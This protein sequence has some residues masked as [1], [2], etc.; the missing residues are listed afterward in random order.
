VAKFAYSAIRDDGERLTGTIEGADR[1]TV[2]GRLNA[3]G[4]HPIDVSESGQT[5]TTGRVLSFGGG[6]A[7]HREIS[8]FTRELA[9]LLR[10][11]MHLNNALDILSKEAF[12]P[13][14]SAMIAALR[15]DIRKGRSFHEALGGLGVFSGF[16]VSMVEAG[17]AS[18]TL[19]QV[20]ERIAATRDREKKVRDRLK[21][22][23]TYPSLL[24]TLAT[25]AVVFILTT[26]VPGIKDMIES[27]GAPVPDS[28]RLVIA[29]SDW[30]IA[31]GM[32]LLIAIPSVLLLAVLLLGSGGIQR[33]FAGIGMRLPLIG[34]VMR[35]SAVL[36]FTRVL[37]T[38]LAAGVSLPDSLKLVRPS[39]ADRRMG[40]AIGA[41]ETA[42]R[43]GDDFLAPLERSRMFPMLLVRMLRVGNETGNLTPSVLQVTD[44]LEEELNG[45]IDRTLTLLEPAIILC[46]SVIV[47][48]IITSL[49]SAI[50]GLNDLAT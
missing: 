43:R 14:F 44:I 24:V 22:A 45:A 17:E 30:L 49:M 9:W 10:S 37:G 20:L 50:I 7:S 23:L 12:G 34:G 26:V 46:L 11:G 5:V 33:L 28:S 47:A 4:L 36:Q 27:S 29:T 48:F 2:I 3:Q 8:V 41:M 6:A 19:P 16:Y 38:L 35:K 1:S 42:L 25:G 15:T 13:A 31:N 21:S 39:I 18:G 32:T 40:D